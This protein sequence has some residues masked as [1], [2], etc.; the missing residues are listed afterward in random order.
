MNEYQSRS[1]IAPVDRIARVSVPATGVHSAGQANVAEA[2]PQAGADLASGSEDQLASAAEYVRVRAKIAN[3]LANMR[4][5]S[6]P[7]LDVVAGGAAVAALLPPPIIIVP[8]PPASKE[9]LA[10]A[11]SLAKEMVSRSTLSLVAQAHIKP[12][13]VDQILAAVA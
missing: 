3:I 2:K 1:D 7:S 10:R 5:S 9:M 12:G 6:S 13:T 8:L 11:E 4:D